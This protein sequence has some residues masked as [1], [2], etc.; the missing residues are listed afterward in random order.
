M[1]KAVAATAKAAKRHAIPKP[2]CDEE[3]SKEGKLIREV[4]FGIQ[5]GIVTVIGIIAGV[6]VLGNKS[7]ILLSAMAGL[8]GETISMTLGGYLSTKSQNEFYEQELRKEKEH[9]EKFPEWEKQEV[10]EFYSAKG[11]KGR[12]LDSIVKIITSSKERWLDIMRAEEFG[13][14]KELDKPVTV[15]VVI[16]FASIAGGF[17]PVIPFLLPLGVQAA[18]IA[19]ITI[20]L[21]TL[22][23]GGAARTFFTKKNW[24]V[25]GM[26]MMAIGLVAAAASYGIGLL[27]T[28]GLV[29]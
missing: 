17:L 4:V 16:G 12:E 18:V 28:G 6:S 25:S 21:A 23:A 2:E 1:K 9:L 7:I 10:R 11:F 26:E 3:H 27:L 14:P 13:F 8:L 29:F 22:F 24:L 15:G 19:A 20:A 5:D